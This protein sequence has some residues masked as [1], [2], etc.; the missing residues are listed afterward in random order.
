MKRWMQSAG[1]VCGLLAVGAGPVLLRGAEAQE[2]RTVKIDD[3][4]GPLSVWTAVAA[5]EGSD[6]AA[7]PNAKLTVAAE[8][9][10]VKTGKG[11]LAYSYTVKPKSM[12]LLVLPKEQ[13][14]SGMKSLRFWAKSGTAT[15]VMVGIGERSGATYQTTVYCPAGEWQEVVVNLD[16]LQVDDPK[17]D[18]NGKLDLDQVASFTVAD[19]AGFLV[20]AV[21]DIQG[22]RTLYLDDIALSSQAAPVTSGRTKNSA[23]KPIFLL[24]SFETPTIRWTPITLDVANGFKF[25]AFDLPLRVDGDVPAGGGKGSLQASYTRAAGKLPV[26]MRDVAKSDLKGVTGLNFHIK[27]SRDGTFMIGIEEKDG[28]RYHKMMELKAGDLWNERA[29]PFPT[30]TLAD[31]SQDE[32]GQLDAEQIKQVSIVDITALLGADLGGANT[33]Y[34]DQLYFTLE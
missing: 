12:S 5:Q 19:I 30:V 11:A 7:D 27:T 16:D 4:E 2:T 33:V 14:L 29:L 10:Q 20:N 31:D 25:N 6:I 15:G 18:A 17:K 23:G 22:T 24:D 28:S 8:A 1:V 34:V 13:D 32:N 9:A 3:F 21:P 26:I